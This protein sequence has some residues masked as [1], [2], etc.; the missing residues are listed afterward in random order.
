VLGRDLAL[1]VCV[2]ARALLRRL[3]PHY[4]D[5]ALVG[6]FFD[7]YCGEKAS[8]TEVLYEHPGRDAYLGWWR[9]E[10]NAY[11]QPHQN[12]VAWLYVSWLNATADLEGLFAASCLDPKGPRFPPDAV[13]TAVAATWVT[14]DRTGLDVFE[15]MEHPSGEPESVEEQISG[16]F[17]DMGLSGRRM[18]RHIPLAETEHV[19]RHCFPTE[20]ETL[21]QTLRTAT[22]KQQHSLN[23]LLASTRE[24]FSEAP[25]IVS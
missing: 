3:A 15:R 4:K 8:A 24:L 11:K 22:E 12:G 17:L 13:M 21:I 10:L 14:C 5:E 25:Q 18:R 2:D 20:A 6:A 1:P 7:L 19:V 9:Q 16:A 23:K